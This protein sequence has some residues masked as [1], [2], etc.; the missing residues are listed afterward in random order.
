MHGLDKRDVTCHDVTQQ[1]EFGLY[2]AGDCRLVTGA[3]PR[4]LHSANTYSLLV[5]RTRTNF[6][7]RAVSVAE[8]RL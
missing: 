5:S 8:Q 3:C 4:T 7:D 6:G 1:V 2:L